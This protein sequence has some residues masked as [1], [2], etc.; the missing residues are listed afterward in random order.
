MEHGKDCLLTQ[1]SSAP[2]FGD[3]SIT[4][5]TREQ[6]DVRLIEHE[7]PPQENTYT[8]RD[9]S[10]RDLRGLRA[11][12]YAQEEHYRQLADRSSGVTCSAA[13]EE[14]DEYKR[15][16]TLRDLVYGYE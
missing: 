4:G 12:C 8:L 10:A 5:G 9:I 14:R 2:N 1:S 7:P 6:R 11:A 16:R 3:S 15:L 13:R